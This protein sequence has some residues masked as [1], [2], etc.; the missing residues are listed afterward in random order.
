VSAVELT[1]AMRTTGTCRYF[2]SEPVPDDVL[3]AAFDVARFGPQ[4]GNRQPVRWIVVR[5]AARKQALADLYLPI[6]KAYLAGIGTGEVRA[7]ALPKTVQDADHFAEHLAEA[8]ALIVVCAEVA[9]LHPTDTELDRVSVVGGASIYPTVQNLCLA[10]R[11]RGVGSAV[12][13]LLCVTEPQVRE[14]LEI[15]DDYLTAA[16]VAVGYPARPFPTK[17]TRSPVEDI[18]S[19]ETFGRP[20]F[21]GA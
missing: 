9:G 21:D 16:H 11:D 15:P 18:V 7:D 6:W 17:L 12:T 10:L 14:L 3:R 8:P 1:E 13:T 20:L 2:T 4:G 5:D 19:A